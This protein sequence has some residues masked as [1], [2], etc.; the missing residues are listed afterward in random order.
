LYLPSYF[1]IIVHR[2]VAYYVISRTLLAVPPSRAIVVAH[3]FVGDGLCPR[4]L[5]P[6]MSPKISFV[7]RP[8]Y[9]TLPMHVLVR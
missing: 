9:H 8:L 6:S 1:I 7:L 4:F 3:G 5:Q 2:A